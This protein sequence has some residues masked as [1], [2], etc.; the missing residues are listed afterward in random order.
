MTSVHQKAP[1]ETS[2]VNHERRGF[3]ATI[4]VSLAQF[5]DPTSSCTQTSALEQQQQ[6]QQQLSVGDGYPW[7]D[8]LIP[9][10]GSSLS[11]PGGSWRVKGVSSGSLLPSM[12]SS[13]GSRFG[14]TFCGAGC[15]AAR[16]PTTLGAERLSAAQ[17]MMRT[18]EDET[19]R[20]QEALGSKE[21]KR[22][23]SY[24][25]LGAGTAP[26]L[27]DRAGTWAPA[28]QPLPLAL[29][30]STTPPQ[31]LAPHVETNSNGDLRPPGARLP[32]TRAMSASTAQL[33]PHFDADAGGRGAGG[34][35]RQP[36]TRAMSSVTTGQSDKA[37]Q[38]RAGAGSQ[39]RS[40]RDP[41]L[42]ALLAL[43]GAK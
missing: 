33:A 19:R 42:S 35:R 1:A 11:P 23:Q 43:Y 40:P 20:I 15:H 24:L 32:G 25:H 7:A 41:G 13:I 8:S 16:L 31:Q 12:G 26:T 36:G 10:M 28:S 5:L 4:P 9:S 27:D 18:M 21:K 30:R 3:G 22:S 17:L 14:H 34:H 38:L 2:M 29:A 39:P 6:R 37:T